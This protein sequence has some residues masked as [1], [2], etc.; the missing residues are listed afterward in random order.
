M[1]GVLLRGSPR[2]R[3]VRTRSPGCA[4]RIRDSSVHILRQGDAQVF[5]HVQHPDV[6]RVPQGASRNVEGRRPAVRYVRAGHWA[7]QQD[8]VPQVRDG[9]GR[10]A[11][12]CAHLREANPGEGHVLNALFLV[13][14]GFARRHQWSGNLDYA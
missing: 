9:Q 2:L 6:P 12:H 10:H 13:L 14:A 3:A 7:D 1:W 4:R 8:S 5:Q 11:M